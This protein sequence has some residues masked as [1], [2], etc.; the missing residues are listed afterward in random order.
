MQVHEQGVLVPD[1]LSWLLLDQWYLH[2]SPKQKHCTCPTSMKLSVATKHSRDHEDVEICQPDFD[3]WQEL[4]QFL[5]P[6]RPSTLRPF[7]YR[8]QWIDQ[9]H[10]SVVVVVLL[11]LLIRVFEISLTPLLLHRFVVMDECG[12]FEWA[13]AIDM[14]ICVEKSLQ[15]R[16]FD[17][18]KV[19]AI[20]FVVHVQLWLV[21]LCCFLQWYFAASENHR[22]SLVG[23]RNMMVML[24]QFLLLL[25]DR[26]CQNRSLLLLWF[27]L[28]LLMDE[29][30]KSWVVEL[31]VF[32]CLYVDTVD[33]SILHFSELS[34]LHFEP[35]LDQ[36]M[37][38]D[39]QID[40]HRP[41]WAD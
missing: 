32:Y 38:N 17:I 14:H 12:W 40:F 33:T 39:S 20:L 25:M 31:A 22:C 16:H 24:V 35:W 29:M 37:L 11:H 23:Q 5:Q 8:L 27:V 7:F 26:I 34:L 2:H 3:R 9:A 4:L 18:V 15:I 30:L 41:R 21:E 19:V 28:R 6:E 13:C 36:R 1:P 10:Q